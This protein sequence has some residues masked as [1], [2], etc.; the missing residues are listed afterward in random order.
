[1]IKVFK[2]LVTVNSKGE[3]F[4]LRND[5]EQSP[6]IRPLSEVLEEEGIVRDRILS[7][8]AEEQVPPY[9]SMSPYPYGY[10]PPYPSYPGY[11]SSPVVRGMAA[12]VPPP[13]SYPTDNVLPASL[14]VTIV[15]VS[16]D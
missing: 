10:P 14:V 1:M 11:P 3:L 5:G 9:P 2:T 12:P 4:V 6:S 7:F 8:K 16:K 13:P 15:Y